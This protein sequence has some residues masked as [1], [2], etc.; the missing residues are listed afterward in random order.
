MRQ[1]LPGGGTSKKHQV[2]N[3]CTYQIF[4]RDWKPAEG[5]VYNNETSLEITA[6]VDFDLYWRPNVGYTNV[7]EL[8]IDS[9]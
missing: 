3:S 1:R 9:C 8:C 5:F 4:G 6:K 2:K 7:C